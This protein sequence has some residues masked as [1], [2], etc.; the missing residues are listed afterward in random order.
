MDLNSRFRNRPVDLRKQICYG[1]LQE[2]L[3]VKIS[4]S[5]QERLKLQHDL[6]DILVL[7]I[8]NRCKT[9]SRTA[10][11]GLLTFVSTDGHF[12]GYTVVDAGEIV[13]LSARVEDRGKQ[14]F[15]EQPGSMDFFRYTQHMEELVKM[16][17]FI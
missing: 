17:K 9:E 15:I 13:T 10:H 1:Q 4:D 14:F 6:R 8:I 11:D 2:L 7:A 3:C 5:H 12:D 16:L